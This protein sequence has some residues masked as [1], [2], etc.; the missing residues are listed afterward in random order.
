MF[1]GRLAAMF[2][3]LV[4]LV[5]FAAPVR[6][7]TPTATSF[8]T[9]NET[10]DITAGPDGNLWFTEVGT[11][12]GRLRT[13]GGLAETSAGI[14]PGT[15]LGQITVG[16]DG[17]LWVTEPSTQSVARIPTGGFATE[18]PVSVGDTRPTGI[19]AGPSVSK[20]WYT[21]QNGPFVGEIGTDGT[22]HVGRRT[23]TLPPGS[24]ALLSPLPYH[25]AGGGR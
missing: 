9:D 17:N 13:D 4:A 1:T 24:R 12:L 14:T 6:A 3:G 25:A 11:K 5:A 8:P 19:T 20:V 21:Q 23:G 10:I 18:F 2:T 22:R 16:N 15:T 7:A